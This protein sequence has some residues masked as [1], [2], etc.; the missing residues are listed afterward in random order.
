MH[1]KLRRNARFKR[2][3]Q[4]SIHIP[5]LLNLFKFLILPNRE[6][7]IRV[8]DLWNYFNEFSEKSFPDLL[9]NI[10]SYNA[11]GVD[12]ASYSSTMNDSMRQIRAPA[13][14]DK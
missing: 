2:L 4:H 11:F 14:C 6:D 12:F 13:E 3:R 1:K 7:I 9:T 5:N 10:E 8:R